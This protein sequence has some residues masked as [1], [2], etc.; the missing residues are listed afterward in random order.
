MGS[1]SVRTELASGTPKDARHSSASSQ[2][3]ARFRVGK[4]LHRFPVVDR[5]TF[6]ARLE[7]IIAKYDK[8]FEGVSDEVDLVTGEIVVDNGHLRSLKDYDDLDDGNSAIDE[9]AVELLHEFLES[10]SSMQDVVSCSHCA[11]CIYQQNLQQF[12]TP[13]QS[14]SNPVSFDDKDNNS[15]EIETTEQH[16][17]P[18]Q[19]ER[20][21]IERNS[22]LNKG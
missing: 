21:D 17:M 13:A 6:K 18:A 10:Q 16:P 14:D 8:D 20:N 15:P 1:S 12:G 19:N 11:L 4:Y 9:D 3:N 2:S 7:S 5:Q 22:Y